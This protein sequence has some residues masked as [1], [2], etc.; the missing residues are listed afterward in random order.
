MRGCVLLGIARASYYR[1]LN[2][3]V[4][5]GVLT[6]V[7]VPH[8]DRAYPNRVS[9]AEAEEV[10]NSLNSEEIADMSIRQGYFH[11]LD[12]GR[13]LCSLSTMHRIMRAA[14]QSADRRRHATHQQVGPRS[15]PRL[16]A[17]GPGQV[18]CW[19]I[20]NLPGPGRYV[21]KLYSMIDLYSRYVVGH[22][23]EMTEDK[24]FT[25][26]LFNNAFTRQGCTPQVIHADNGA[27]MRAGTVRELMA[28]VQ[29]HASYSRPRVSNDNAFA[30]ALFKTVKYDLAYPERFDSLEHARDWAQEFFEQYNTSHHHASLAGHTPARVH[31]G[32]WQQTHDQWTATKTAYATQHPARHP[33]QPVTPTPPDTV[34]INK[35]NQLSQTA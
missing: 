34:W 9:P 13:Y 18:W 22:R 29:V 33:R 28:A 3:P 7:V 8:R 35:P 12:Q 19:D 15:T 14:G 21:F 5:T 32:T 6:G 30:E 23:V 16:C 20:T 31:D 17:T 11:L 26:G 24:N 27:V 1:H 2:P 25:E 10:I 4:L